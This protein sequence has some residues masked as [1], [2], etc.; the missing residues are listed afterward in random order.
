MTPTAAIAFRANAQEARQTASNNIKEQAAASG[1]SLSKDSYKNAAT[2]KLNSTA[3]LG[4]DGKPVIT[5]F[6]WDPTTRT[7]SIS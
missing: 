3:K 7:V 5:K 1:M 4:T 2:A 6:T